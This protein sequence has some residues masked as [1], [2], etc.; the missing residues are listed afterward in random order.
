MEP[1]VL[2][3]SYHEKRKSENMRVVNWKRLPNHM[4]RVES[5]TDE[6]D[7][8][9]RL[10]IQQFAQKAGANQEMQT[11]AG[12]D[13][14]WV[15]EWMRESPIKL[16]PIF[17]PQRVFNA[18]FTQA[19]TAQTLLSWDEMPVNVSINLFREILLKHNFEDI[20]HPETPSFPLRML[21]NE[22]RIKARNNGIL[23]YSFVLHRSGKPLMPGDYLA[24]DILVSP[25]HPLTSPKPLRERGIKMLVAGF[26]DLLPVSDQVYKQRLENWRVKWASETLETRALR[27]FEAH[28]IL[29]EG[30]R[31]GMEAMA[32]QLRRIFETNHNDEAIAI[33]LMQ[34]LEGAT[35]DPK[36]R[37]LLPGDTIN[38]LRNI[39][40]WLK[41]PSS[42]QGGSQLTPGD[43][44][45]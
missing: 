29:N 8:D 42:S 44:I 19:R 24:S 4:I 34:A 11:F 12:L 31:Q 27:E 10:E 25:V 7:D 37:Q 36:T 35:S 32:F 26:N 22:L 23:S 28:R 21:R 40:Y 45:Q 30:R 2:P 1:D 14:E 41:P 38:L 20:F 3:I 43:I 17:E 16:T 9:D 6:L 18:V 39:G 15:R 5:L 13:E 33:A